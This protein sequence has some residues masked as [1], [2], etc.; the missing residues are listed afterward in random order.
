LDRQQAG[1]SP[2]AVEHRRITLSSIGTVAA[3]AYRTGATINALPAGSPTA[4]GDRL[5]ML[6]YLA[7]R[8]RAQI[9]GVT[10]LRNKYAGQKKTLDSLIA[11]QATPA[12]Y[13][14]PLWMFR[15]SVPVRHLRR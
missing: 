6:D 8:Q 12:G 9:S 1:R 3:H 11:T 2:A 4:L 5:S 15:W 13:R 10:D 7:R 14:R